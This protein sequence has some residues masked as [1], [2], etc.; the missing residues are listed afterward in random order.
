MSRGQGGETEHRYPGQSG[1]VTSVL[2]TLEQELQQRG[3]CV[4]WRVRGM[5]R[6][7]SGSC[8]QAL[9]STEAQKKCLIQGR[10]LLAKTPD[11]RAGSA[12]A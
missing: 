3:G 5:E 8:L 9:P 10:V 7:R 12:E 6:L 4:H 11:V 1:K 2:P